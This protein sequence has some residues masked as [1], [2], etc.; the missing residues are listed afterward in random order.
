MPASS[1]MTLEARA[2]QS[3]GSSHDAI[4]ELVERA[5][6]ERSI[7]GG[8]LVDVGCGGGGLWRLLAQR[9]TDYRGLDAVR[10]PGFPIEAEFL[11]IDL[12]RTP[13]PIASGEADVVAA[14]ETIEHLENPWTFMRALIALVRPGGWVIVTTPNQLS[15]LSL[16]T[17][18]V[19]GR[20]SAFQEVHYPAH[21]TALLEID[22]RR[23]ADESGLE[24][25]AVLYSHAGRVPFTAW[26]YP[27]PLARRFPRALSDNVLIIGRKPALRAPSS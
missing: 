24:S 20:F 19:K 14:V 7:A 27:P 12:D 23:L 1:A 26:H 18:I 5:L 13:W 11:E 8:L 6:A 4:Y 16:A 3:L 9:F 22:L 21:R 2:R 10:Y 15:L 25:V 17:L